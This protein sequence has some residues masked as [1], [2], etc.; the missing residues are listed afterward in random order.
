MKIGNA[1]KDSS[2]CNKAYLRLD[3][4]H[5]AKRFLQFCKSD[6]TRLDLAPCSTEF[7][8]TL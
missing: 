6:Q 2:I 8:F 4:L 3:N 5:G 1:K 7:P